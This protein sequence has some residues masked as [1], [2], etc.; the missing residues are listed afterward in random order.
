MFCWASSRKR[1]FCNYI[2]QHI[3]PLEK[4]ASDLSS[5][6]CSCTITCQGWWFFAWE[7]IQVQTDII[8]VG[9]SVKVVLMIL[10]IKMFFLSYLDKLW[11]KLLVCVGQIWVRLG[12]LIWTWGGGEERRPKRTSDIIRHCGILQMDWII[13][14]T[15][16]L[17]VRLFYPRSPWTHAYFWHYPPSLWHSARIFDI[18]YF[19]PFS[20]SKD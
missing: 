12:G 9:F 7:N 8:Y 5:Y 20:L 11:G 10:D 2:V 15:K 16:L 1:V 14:K 18:C 4:V 13:L 3:F 19:L 17:I 6:D